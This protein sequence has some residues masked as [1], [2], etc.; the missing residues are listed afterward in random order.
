MTTSS[1]EEIEGLN[2]TN[3]PLSEF[4][5]TASI[6]RSVDKLKSIN[7][8]NEFDNLYDQLQ[9]IYGEIQIDKTNFFLVVVKA[10]EITDNFKKIS[11]M[12][13]KSLVVT[14]L[15]K[16]ITELD[17]D[18][19]LEKELLSESLDNIIDKIIEKSSKKKNKK[20]KNKKVTKLSVGKIINELVSKLITLF[21]EKEI[22]IT[23]LLFRMINVVSKLIDLVE[24]YPYLSKVEKKEVVVQSIKIFINNK[25]PE[26][27][28][29]NNEE[30]QSLII[31]NL[32]VPQLVDGLLA[33]ETNDILSNI[34]NNRIL[35]KIMICC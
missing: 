18:D 6:S 13:K 23:D 17:L 19:N 22:N 4:N 20:K 14:V 31:A 33:I 34:R 1:V 16:I 29:M 5:R 24:D 27:I 8:D 32:L 3:N 9:E 7:E 35:K 11:G 21:S 30:K 25:L 28:D 2:E 26:L 10:V 12:D 15:K